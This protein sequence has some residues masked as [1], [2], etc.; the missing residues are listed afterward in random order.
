MS[1]YK[2]SKEQKEFMSKPIDHKNPVKVEVW[3]VGTNEW[4][5]RYPII[6]N[7]D[8]SLVY[9]YSSSDGEYLKGFQFEN[10]TTNKWRP[11]PQPKTRPMTKD[12]ILQGKK[13]KKGEELTNKL[14][15]VNIDDDE[16]ELFVEW[17][18]NNGYN[19]E[20]GDGNLIDGVTG[21]RDD[22]D[23]F[24]IHNE[25]WDQYCNRSKELTI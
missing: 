10:S 6:F 22:D 14:I 18:N 21:M 9:I 16:A 8:G 4:K 2:F 1:D 23:L 5:K 7:D 13:G 20:I 12:E 24:D 11:I 25:L 19:A 17:L 15:T 3:F